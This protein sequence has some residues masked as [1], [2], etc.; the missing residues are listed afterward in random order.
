MEYF[1]YFGGITRDVGRFTREIG[2]RVAMSKVT[3]NRKKTL[4]TSKLDLHLRKKLV[5]YYIWI[6]AL[7]GAVTWT[8]WKGHQKRMESFEMWCW[9]KME[10]ISWTDCVKNEKVSRRVKEERN[11]LHRVKI[12]KD[13]WIGHI[14]CRNCF[15]KHVI[16]MKIARR[17]GSGR[18]YKKLPDGHKGTARYWTLK[19]EALD[20]TVWRTGFGRGYRP[21]V[22]RKPWW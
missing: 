2:S 14:L 17:G 13:D 19:E 20:C 22:R 18:M 1:K 5:K 8:V 3:F 12:R 21:V 4:F 6:I 7:C 9:R 10:K 11:I 15:L 16:E